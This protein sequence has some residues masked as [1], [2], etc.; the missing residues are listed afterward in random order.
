MA[1][2]NT[3]AGAQVSILY[4]YHISHGLARSLKISNVWVSIL[5][6]YHISPYMF[7]DFTIEGPIGVD[8][9]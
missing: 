6:K 2:E 1:F 8:P 3:Y 5:Y 7:K 9:L 4:K